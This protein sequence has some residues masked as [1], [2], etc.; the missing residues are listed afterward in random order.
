MLGIVTGRLIVRDSGEPLAGFAVYLGDLLPLTPGPDYLITMDQKASPNTAL[1][2]EGN[3][4]FNNVTPGTYGVIA[5]APVGSRV[6]ADPLQPE[7][8]LLI[9]VEAGKTV[10]LGDIPVDWP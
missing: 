8:E 7:K 2:A 10:A 1:D 6:L 3:F 9:V 4:T 5:W